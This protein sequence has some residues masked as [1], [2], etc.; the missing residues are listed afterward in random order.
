[1]TG[2]VNVDW[3]GWLSGPCTDPDAAALAQLCQR[4]PAWTFWTGQ[5][6]GQYWAAP[7]R[8][9]ACRAL[10]SADTPPALAALITEVQAWET[11]R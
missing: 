10:L 11:G 1:M 3:G 9:S 8:G 2:P 7:P 4:F 6:T 5:H